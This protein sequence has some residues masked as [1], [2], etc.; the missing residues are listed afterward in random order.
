MLLA[1]WR[2]PFFLQKYGQNTKDQD[3]DKHFKVHGKF[4]LITKGILINQSKTDL[5]GNIDE[6][7][8][9]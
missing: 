7:D 8:N 5:D 3:R 1:S 6:I 2:L 4:F 9:G